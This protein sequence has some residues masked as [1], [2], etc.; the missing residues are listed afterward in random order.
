[1][2]TATLADRATVGVVEEEVPLKLLP[3]RR[4]SEPPERCRLP[5]GEELHAHTQAQVGGGLLGLPFNPARLLLTPQY[6]A[7]TPLGRQRLEQ[8]AKVHALNLRAAFA[9]LTDQQVRMLNTLLDLLRPEVN[10]HPA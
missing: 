8:A 1:V 7:I 9:P 5:I 3:G 10:L 6:A 2:V 4:P